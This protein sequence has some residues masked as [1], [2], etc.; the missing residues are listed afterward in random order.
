MINEHDYGTPGIRTAV[1]ATP[2]KILR[3]MTG[4]RYLPGGKVIDGSKSRDVTNTGDTD[5]LQSGTVMG[6][7][8]A[9]GKY[10]PSIIGNIGT[11]YGASATNISAGA[12][13][14]TELS[15]LN[16][17]T[18]TFKLVGG[19]AAAATPITTTFTHSAIN[20]TSGLIT[21]AALGTAQI[22]GS[23]VMPTDGSET[24]KGI[25]E[26]E[27]GLKV[28]DSSGNSQDTSMPLLL[29]GGFIDASEIVNYPSD[30]GLQTWLKTLLNAPE[31][32]A[33]AINFDDNF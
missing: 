1:S 20:V 33:G 15:R 6:K 13:V 16:G 8:S 4:A 14:A 24:P 17:A 21:V 11:A 23:F 22:V 28:T 29:I 9:S 25:M 27:Y 26:E 3:T 19:T 30:T 7:I 18:G 31:A 10:R 2:K 5:T 12:S 32:G